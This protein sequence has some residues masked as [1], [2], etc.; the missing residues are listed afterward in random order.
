VAA[1]G[2]STPTSSASA[3]AGTPTSS[4]TAS[5]IATATPS[6]TPVPTAVPVVGTGAASP[7][8][9]VADVAKV[10]PGSGRHVSGDCNGSSYLVPP[11]PVTQR[12]GARLDAHPFS[13][14]GGG[15]DPLCRCQGLPTPVFTLMSESGTTAY[16]HEDLG[17]GPSDNLRW[18]V[19]SIDGP[20]YVDDQDT[21]CSAT[22]IYD[23]AYDY[24][25]A[26]ST[27][28]PPAPSC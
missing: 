5:S 24:F 18:R 1:C 7:V 28:A 9:A 25:T 15:A 22:T 26:G 21:G 13:G 6:A 3:P 23:P 27:P 10:A 17:F 20:W 16:V 4:P 12:L 11:C 14:S 19:V 8:L 2:A